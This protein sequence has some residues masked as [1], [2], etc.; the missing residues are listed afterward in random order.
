MCRATLEY[1][2]KRFL[3]AKG[4]SLTVNQRDE[5]RELDLIS[6]IDMAA[7]HLGNDT[8]LSELMHRVRK[9]GN[10]V[11]HPAAVKNVSERP[12]DRKQALECIE[13][14]RQVL[15]KVCR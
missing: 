6:L 15:R 5:G 8:Q 14:L 10:L 9:R 1:A 12:T 11:L 13:A 7:V 4:A 2:V 3:L